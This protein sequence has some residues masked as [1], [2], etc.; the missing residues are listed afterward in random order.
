MTLTTRVVVRALAVMALALGGVCLLT[1][2]LVLVSGRDD[3]DRLVRDVADEIAS[4][5]SAQAAVAAGLDGSLTGPEAERAA[6]ATLAT[7][8]SSS[9]HMAMISLPDVRLQATG[10]PT[11][12]AALLRGSGAPPVEPGRLRT[13]DSAV[14]PIRALDVEV[15]DPNQSTLAVVSVLAPL[16]ASRQAA[17]D[18]LW[19]SALAAVLALIVGGVVLT[20]VVR[21]ALG[22]LREL[23]A[24]ANAITPDAL[25]DRIQV[26]D[27]GDEV[28][29]LARELNEMLDRIDADDQTRRR[30]LAAISH[31]VRTP[32]TVAEG[33]LELLEQG[34]DDPAAVAGTVRQELDRLRRVLDDLLSVARGGEQ[35]AI[36]LGPVFLPE[37]FTAV[38]N[39]VDALGWSNRVTIEPPPAAAFTGDQARIEQCIANLVQN[40]IDHN[41]PTTQVTVTGTVVGGNVAI[42]V[43][44][45]GHGI[46]PELRHRVREPF[47]TSKTSGHGRTSGLGLAVVDALTTA[48]GGELRLDSKPTGTTAT[49][50]HPIDPPAPAQHRVSNHRTNQLPTA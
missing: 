50:L 1:Y 36:R 33:H 38:A 39:R 34:H 48:Q 9:R 22:P 44:D 25:T 16:D 46:D 49:L 23:S 42:T 2:Q 43:S 7:Q 10:G 20:I 27:S 24:A 15:I 37:L 35:A 17:A 4:T 5:L 3:V 32:L 13:V 26:P 11:E 40:A 19:R 45:D 31:E 14:G 28:E 47:V 8:P 6:R 30:Y 29:Q 21:R 18:A 12:V 41:P